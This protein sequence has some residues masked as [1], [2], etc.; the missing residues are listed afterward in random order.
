MLRGWGR[1]SSITNETE[2]VKMRYGTKINNIP[3]DSKFIFNEI[4]Y[5]FLPSELGAAFGLAQLKKITTFKK[6]R[7]NNFNTLLK[8]FSG[9]KKYFILPS[10]DTDIS[11]QWLAFPLTIRK[12]APFERISLV[13][14]LEG[15]NIQ[16]RPIFTGN[17]LQQPGFKNIIHKGQSK[18]PIADQIMNSGLLVGCHHGLQKKHIHI[19]ID[20][21]EEFLSKF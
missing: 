19:L 2:N 10:Q 1:G 5:N 18:Y 15:R 11:T 3:Y 21:F 4:G 6:I 8:Y 20:V 16:T 12:D 13:T 17:I 7:E 9:Y 14:F